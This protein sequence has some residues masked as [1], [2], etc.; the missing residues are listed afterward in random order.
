MQFNGSEYCENGLQR[1]RT[2][3][4]QLARRYGLSPDDAED[5]GMDFVLHC[6]LHGARR[7]GSNALGHCAEPRMRVCVRHFV[8]NFMRARSR[9]LRFEAVGAS[10]LDVL[11]LGCND[12]SAADP[13]SGERAA[14]LQRAVEALPTAMRALVVE[15]YINRASC[16]E[17]AQ[18]RQ[19]SVHAIEQ[20]LYRSRSRL[21]QIHAANQASDSDEPSAVRAAASDQG[22]DDVRREV[23]D[24][25]GV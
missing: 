14:D 23:K 24:T 13:R 12:P 20:G 18:R 8:L 21:R 5:C 2:H 9:R 1:L 11:T 19:C 22:F 4:A 17:I 15:H 6:L 7:C 16:S 3:G 25:G 10:P